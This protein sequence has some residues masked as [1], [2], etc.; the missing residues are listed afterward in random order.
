VFDLQGQRIWEDRGLPLFDTAYDIC[1]CV[2]RARVEYAHEFDGT[3]HATVGYADLG[4]GAASTLQIAPTGSDYVNAG[5]GADVSFASCWMVGLDY[6][7]A[8]GQEKTPP[9]TLQMK[10]NA[11]F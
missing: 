4:A 1:R 6:R 8:F 3:S 2:P 11:R 5:L 10:L 7:T 9:Q